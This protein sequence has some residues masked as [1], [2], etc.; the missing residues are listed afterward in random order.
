MVCEMLIVVRQGDKYGPDYP[1]IIKRMAKETSNL[2]TLILGDG[3]DA[4]IK[5]EYA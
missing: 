4:D 5:L 2:D 1:Q 3:E